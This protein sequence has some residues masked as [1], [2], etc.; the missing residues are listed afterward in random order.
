[1]MNPVIKTKNVLALVSMLATAGNLWVSRYLLAE[2][3]KAICHWLIL[4]QPA[5]WT[6]CIQATVAWKM[7][8]ELGR[9]TYT[10]PNPLNTDINDVFSIYSLH[11]SC[12]SAVLWWST[13]RHLSLIKKV[14]TNAVNEDPFWSTTK[15]LS[16]TTL[17][18]KTLMVWKN[19]LYIIICIGNECKCVNK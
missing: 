4:S 2:S 6:T 14:K 5:N 18:K 17:I 1:M 15:Y 13:I 12:F 11:I 3:N 19:V 8:A 10:L 16:A 7:T 9:W